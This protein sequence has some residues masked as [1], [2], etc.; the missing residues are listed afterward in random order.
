MD[1]VVYKRKERIKTIKGF[2]NEGLLRSL[3]FYRECYDRCMENRVDWYMAEYFIDNI[4]IIKD[5][6]EK[7]NISTKVN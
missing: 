7:R 2:D 1:L 6:M 4:S 5:E 3:T